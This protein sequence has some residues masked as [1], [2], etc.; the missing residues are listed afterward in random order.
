MLGIPD[1]IED[2]KKAVV[3]L[4]RM[5]TENQPEF[6]ATGCLLSL[7]DV[8]HLV[9]AKHV[10]VD[11]ETGQ[12]NDSGLR[13]FYNHKTGGGAMRSLEDVKDKFGVKWIFHSDPNV[14]IALIPFG[15]D[16]TTDDVLTIPPSLFAKRER[17]FQLYDVFQLSYQPGVP[18]ESRVAPIIRA[19]TISKINK[20]GSLYIDSAA[21]PGNSGSP[22]FLTPSP[23]RFDKEGISLGGDPIG[24]HFVGIVGS[25]VPYQE[26]AISVQT[27][28]PRII[29][30]ENTG[31]SKVWPPSFIEE[32]A[33][34]EEF[35]RQ[36]ERVLSAET[37]QETTK[38]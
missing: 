34:S 33:M 2:V 5:S 32:A 10:V 36:I 14:D 6:V 18:D 31:L 27:K 11:L 35:R 16:M 25:Y 13:V 1:L 20:D 38:T 17:L 37:A 21:F 24:G 19:G 22:V 23:I 30:E 4:G 3:F 26:I 9:T 28:R 15:I 12:L 29:F 7:H 8:V